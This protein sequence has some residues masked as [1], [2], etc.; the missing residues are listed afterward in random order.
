VTAPAPPG[1]AGGPD[2]SR[3]SWRVLRQY[4]RGE[5]AASTAVNLAYRGSVMIWV[6]TSVIQPIVLIVVWR[7]IAG[8]SGSVGG[9]TA[10][11]FVT[12]FAIMLLVDHLTFI[13]LMWEFEWRIR[14][15][16]FSPLLL[17]P[18]HP[19]HKDITDNV[20][21]KI[22]GLLGVG[23]AV[24]ILIL[25]FDGDL[26]GI[27][28]LQVLAFVP[29]LVGGAVL[30]FVIEWVL[31]LSAFWLT[32]VSALNNLYFSVRTFLSGGFAPLSVLPPV[33]AAIA[34]WSP[35]PWSQAFVVNV[36]MGETTGT[37]ILVGYGAQAAWILI[38]LALLKVVWSRAV[39]HYSA[40]GA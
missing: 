4:Y 22:I 12:Y 37:D 7:T 39:R 21:Y 6:F 24:V 38:A 18:I 15:G 11:R 34:N 14:E 35:F 32:K 10:D 2:F 1:I 3:F 13:W 27:T 28:P 33:I 5:F 26:S 19:I 40:V 36:V 16:A 29:A 17:R 25:V 30:R 31:A 9:Y 23:P 20:S 8:P